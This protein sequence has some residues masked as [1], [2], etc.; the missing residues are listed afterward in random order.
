MPNL[1]SDIPDNLPNE[2]FSDLLKSEHTRIERIIS[3]GHTSPDTGWYD[4]E[5][6]EWVIVL[7]GEGEIEFESRE[8]IKLGVGEYLNIPA[9]QKHR[10]AWTTHKEPTLWLAVFYR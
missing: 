9:H 2:L 6:H 4:Q 1:F 3:H 10:V 7:K 8:T 5:E